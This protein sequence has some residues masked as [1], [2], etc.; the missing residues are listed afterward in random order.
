MPLRI[1]II[2]AV[3]IAFLVLCTARVTLPALQL[4][5]LVAWAVLATVATLV[6][7]RRTRESRSSDL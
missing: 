1:A 5:G 2:A 7:W 3:V 4:V 6:L